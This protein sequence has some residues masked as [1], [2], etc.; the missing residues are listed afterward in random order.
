MNSIIALTLADIACFA[1]PAQA[2]EIL[3]RVTE[4]IDSQAREIIGR[5]PGDDD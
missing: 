4:A 5:P 3:V 2:L 1:R